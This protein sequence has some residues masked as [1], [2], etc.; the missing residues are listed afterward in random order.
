M[1][2]TALEPSFLHV[3][4]VE[5]GLWVNMTLVSP[6]SPV[7]LEAMNLILQKD[8]ILAFIGTRSE[9]GHYLSELKN[10]TGKDFRHCWTSLPAYTIMSMLGLCQYVENPGRREIVFYGSPLILML[11]YLLEASRDDSGILVDRLDGAISRNG[12]VFLDEKELIGLGFYGPRLVNL[13]EYQEAKSY[14]ND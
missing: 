13:S 5:S 9:F 6:V 4:N 3:Y 8:G 1:H 10:E 12:S 7:F 11:G 14:I 2:P